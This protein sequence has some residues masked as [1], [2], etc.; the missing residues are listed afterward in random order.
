M[1]FREILESFCNKKI[2]EHNLQLSRGAVR[3]EAASEFSF[4][5]WD[6]SRQ[7]VV[8]GNTHRTFLT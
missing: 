8:G 5:F 4:R 3:I 6:G 7:V 1:R 2:G